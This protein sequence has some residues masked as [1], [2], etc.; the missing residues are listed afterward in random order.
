MKIKA[1]INKKD[2]SMVELWS[3]IYP[4]SKEEELTLEIWIS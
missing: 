3:D 4:A 2:S 1:N